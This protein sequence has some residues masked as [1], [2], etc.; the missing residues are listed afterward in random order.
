MKRLIGGQPLYTKDAFVFS[1]A[2]VIFVGNSGTTIT[3]QIRSEHGNIG[4]LSAVEIAQWFNLQPINEETV[5]PIVSETADGFALTV[6]KLHAA[7]IK[8]IVP[9]EMY[10]FVENNFGGSFNVSS[11][12]WS[13]FRD[14]LSL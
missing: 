1:N 6:E 3:Y 8:T 7:N 4:I 5:E 10:N 12:D 14:L 13:R 11:K 9:K 2:S